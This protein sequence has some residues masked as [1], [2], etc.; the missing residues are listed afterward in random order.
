MAEEKQNTE[1]ETLDVLGAPG[2]KQYGGK[3]YEEF[4][5]DLKG[6]KA[7]RMFKEMSMNEPVIGG[8]LYAIRTLVRQ[9][10]FEVREASDTPEAKAAA[11]FVS[12][13]LFKD[14]DQTWTDTL[15]E[16]LSFLVYGFSVHEIT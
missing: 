5:N 8:V 9:T 3:I 13:C 1:T 12:E 15:S 7:T 4:L 14:M 2:L 6:E 16:I 11:A 10:R